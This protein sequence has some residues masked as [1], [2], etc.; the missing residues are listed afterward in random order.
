MAIDNP[1]RQWN[2]NFRLNCGTNI[3]RGRI[4]E[5]G[6]RGAGP[7]TGL[8]LLLLLAV[9]APA[10]DDAQAPPALDLT[11]SRA[12]AD[13]RIHNRE[14]AVYQLGA[15]MAR[16]E[17]AAQQAKYIPGFAW[18]TDWA[19]S[20]HLSPGIEDPSRQE[21]Y[22]SAAGFT[23]DNTLGG[24]AD[25]NVGISRQYLLESGSAGEPDAY[26]AGIYLKYAQPLWRNRGPDMAN[27]EIEKAR[28]RARQGALAADTGEQRL[29]YEVFLA[30]FQLLTTREIWR[31]NCAIRTNSARVY[32]II[33]EQVERR[34]LLI[35]DQK[36]MQATL[37]IQDRAIAG[38]EQRIRHEEDALYFAI[39]NQPRPVPAAPI[40][41]LTD[42]GALLDR[43]APGAV[44]GMLAA[45][46]THDGL[47]RDLRS[48]Q[49]LLE[50]DLR[51]AANDMRPELNMVLGTGIEGYDA[52]SAARAFGDIAPGHYEVS[53]AGVLALPVRN[54]AARERFLR[55]NED[56]RR[57]ELQAANRQAALVNAVREFYE[58]WDTS[59][60]KLELG[61]AIVELS[62]QNMG[63]ELERLVAAKT[64]VLNTL[65]YQNAL[66]AAEVDLRLTQFD[67]L[68]LLGTYHQ[69][70]GDMLLLV[71]EDDRAPA[72]L[73]PPAP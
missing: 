37:L 58:D 67:C 47:L 66:I 54:T 55:A 49:A 24:K 44:T 25:L 17:E 50:Q 5:R 20:R 3:N 40:G 72:G 39:Y 52:A 46:D 42:P 10:A 43:F 11:L 4:V 69:W 22:T 19:K 31:E 1:M 60:R 30:Y 45:A 59:R 35:S 2:S 38:L 16:R 71:T 53:A 28:V 65:D 32:E 8:V 21:Q 64:T 36:R 73:E 57:V 14:L 41:L 68:V 34:K 27:L 48:A 23:R 15:T 26:N 70:R 6:R 33:R 7:G 61:R 29:L 18:S 12:L 63:H 9:A 13:A 62:R 56:L 51:K